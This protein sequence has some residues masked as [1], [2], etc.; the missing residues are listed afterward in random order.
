MRPAPG[1]RPARAPRRLRLRHRLRLWLTLAA[2]L[3][4]A[5]ALLRPGIDWTV[6]TGSTVF[7]ID[8]TQSMNVADMSLEG[9]PATRLDYT[10]A[11]LA[12]VIRE[13]GCGHQ[14]GIGIFTERKTMVLAAPLEVCAHY[15]A[16][17]DIVSA[18]DWRMAWAADSHLY[19]GVYSALDEVGRHWPGATVA[20]FTDGHQAP[21]FHVGQ[22]PRYDRGDRTP[23]GYLFGIGGAE[24]QPVPHV[25]ADGKT[26]GYWTAEEAAAFPPAGPRPTLSVADMEKA[27]AEGQNLR[28]ANSR[29]PPGSESDYLSGRRDSVLEDIASVTG[30]TAETRPPDAAA[31]VAALGRLPGNHPTRR[32][33]DLHD[34]FVGLAA[35]ALLAS[36]VPAP[37]RRQPRPPPNPLP[38]GASPH[39]TT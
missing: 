1:P 25:D 36:L 3:G 10:R 29:R 35:L 23:A 24:P 14:V 8:I 33:V 20:F 27:R 2:A 12:R 26:T 21:P 32:R 28:N 5:I 13:L 31:V 19:Y 37:R 38:R 16:L 4:F 39:E 9:R 18:I 22:T 11:L 15:A 34:G 17:D 7:V 30:L 6:K